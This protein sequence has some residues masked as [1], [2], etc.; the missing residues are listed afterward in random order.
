MKTFLAVV[1]ASILGVAAGAGIAAWRIAV[2]PWDGD[3][4]GTRAG[5]PAATPPSGPAPKVVV[6]QEEYEFGLLDIT[7]KGKHDF[8]FTNRGQGTLELKAGETSC[9]CTVSEIKDGGIAPGESGKV[10]VTWR[11]D[12]GEGPF[13]QTATIETNDPLRPRVT[14][15]VSGRITMVVRPVPAALA[16]GAV[17]AGREVTGQVRLLCYLDEPLDVLGYELANKQTADYFA[18]RFKPL[19]AEE[20]REAYAGEGNQG[21]KEK[22]GG[23]GKIDKEGL[24]RSGYLVDVT[25]KS[26]LPLGGFGQTILVQTGLKSVPTV[27]IPL[28]GTIVGDISIVGRGWDEESGILTLGRIS[29][30]QGAQ[31]RLL[32][33]ARGPLSKQVQF[34]LVRCNPDLLHVDQEK[35]KEKTTLSSGTVTQT[36]L[37]VRIPRGS[38]RAYYLGSE[39]GEILIKTSHPDIPLLRIHV[40]FAIEG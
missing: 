15:T 20:L 17:S 28:A 10:T 8:L 5:T 21:N 11:A 24:P 22:G 36:P 2:A 34:T 35:L 26:G 39:L 14:L 31:R 16:F 6:D 33:V 40:R 13:R 4:G 12:K 27:Q 19:T 23:E 38:P 3:P 32:L 30:N 9:G 18:V 1:L 25:V 37:I 29:T 7:A